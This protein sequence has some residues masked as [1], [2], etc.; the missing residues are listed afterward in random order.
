MINNLI[1]LEDITV[2]DLETIS[3]DSTIEDCEE[4]LYKL[5]LIDKYRFLLE[6]VEKTISK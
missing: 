5:Q 4:L 3:E 1:N 2:S 6:S